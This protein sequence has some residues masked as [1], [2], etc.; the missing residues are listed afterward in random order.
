MGYLG[1]N[2]ERR[3]YL[4]LDDFCLNSGIC[5]IYINGSF[6]CVCVDGVKGKSCEWNLDDCFFIFC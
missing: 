6:L 2:C 4:C 5:L 3:V 1:L